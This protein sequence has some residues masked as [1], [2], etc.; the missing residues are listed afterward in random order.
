MVV[1]D[2]LRLNLRRGI[3]NGS[4]PLCASIR[5]DVSPTIPAEDSPAT[6]EMSALEQVCLPHRNSLEIPFPMADPPLRC[7][8]DMLMSDP[9]PSAEG[10]LNPYAFQLL[11]DIRPG[12]D[13]FPAASGDRCWTKYDT[14]QS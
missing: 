9:L 4:M 1:H 14:Y 11:S 3:C 6:L 7:T 10:C 2:D 13:I 5:P 8:L 12:C